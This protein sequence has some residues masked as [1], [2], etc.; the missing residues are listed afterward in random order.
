VIHSERNHWLVT[1][2]EQASD[3]VQLSEIDT[4][5]GRVRFHFDDPD[6]DGISWTD[7]CFD[8]LREARLLY[9]LRMETGDYH[10]HA[11]GDIP[12]EVAVAGKEAV[13]AFLRAELEYS[14]SGI[15]DKMNVSKQTISNYW[16]RMRW[17]PD[18]E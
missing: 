11:S 4:K 10:V 16:N 2:D 12:V 18:D 7:H 9:G 5:P 8:S 14:R 15:A 3:P 1:D 13:A 17:T 6:A